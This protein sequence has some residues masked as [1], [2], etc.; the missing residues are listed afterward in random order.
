MLVNRENDGGDN[1]DGGGVTLID[2]ILVMS[3]REVADLTGKRHSDVLRDVRNQFKAL[4]I[5]ERKFA[6]GYLDANNQ[7]RKQ[8]LLDREQLEVLVTGYSIP[9]RARVIKR[10]HELESKQQRQLPQTFSEALR[11]LA[12][13]EEEKERALALAEEAERTKAEIGNRREAT[14]MNTASQA[15]KKANSEKERANKAERDLEDLTQKINSNEDNTI[16]KLLQSEGIAISAQ[17]AN[18]ILEGE[19]LFLKLAPEQESDKKLCK[20]RPNLKGRKMG[21]FNGPIKNRYS[22]TGEHRYIDALLVKPEF[23]QEIL[24]LIRKGLAKLD[25]S[26]PELV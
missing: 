23:K 13:S 15:V 16:T 12:D 10:L 9:L 2:G 18:N 24:D 21:L 14:A 6:S 22:K 11:A 19:K 1:A 26:Q 20:R 4:Q 3:T 8:F 25:P 17:Q 7:E 5:D